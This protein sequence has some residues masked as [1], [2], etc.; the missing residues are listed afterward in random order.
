MAAVTGW[1][2]SFNWAHGKEV[3]E[4]ERDT[5]SYPASK[6]CAVSIFNDQ[7]AHH[8]LSL[9]SK[10]H[11]QSEK[12]LLKK[13]IQRKEDNLLP[14]FALSRMIGSRDSADSLTTG[15]FQSPFRIAPCNFRDGNGH[16]PIHFII[17][18]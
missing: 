14:F 6:A 1:T 18:G 5:A 8:E 10:I 2:N 4:R 7:S 16:I 12:M 9:Y 11:P 15:L 13:K 3:D 17:R